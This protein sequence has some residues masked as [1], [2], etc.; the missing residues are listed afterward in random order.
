MVAIVI[1]SCE[2]VPDLIVDPL[3]HGR[4]N[5]ARIAEALSLLV[6]LQARFKGR[7]INIS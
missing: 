2:L 1:G 3:I 4:C 6:D 7:T 5:I